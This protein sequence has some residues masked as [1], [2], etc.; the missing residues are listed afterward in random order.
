MISLEKGIPILKVT[1]LPILKLILRD[2]L[3]LKQKEIRMVIEMVIEMV[4]LIPH[5]G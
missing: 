5:P 4:K 2:F 3:R 1:S